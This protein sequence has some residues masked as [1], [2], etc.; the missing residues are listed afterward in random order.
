[1]DGSQVGEL[2]YENFNAAG[3]VVTIHGK[4][5]HPGYAKGKMVNSMLIATDFIKALPSNEIPQET[6][7][8]EGFF[9]LSDMQGSVEQTT[10]EYIISILGVLIFT[11]L[12]AY[13]VQ[14]LKRIGM[15]TGD[16]F[17]ESKS[18]LAIMGALTLYLDFINLFLFLL[19]FL[20][21]RK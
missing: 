9:H 7:G 4:I 19:R 15:A 3:A 13:D 20:G 11:G 6:E 12:T 21:N 2:E 18:K 14:K 8:Y 10:L 1:M 5:V 16:Y 17:G